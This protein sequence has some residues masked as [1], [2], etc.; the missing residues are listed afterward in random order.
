MIPEIYSDLS[1]EK[2][3]I[4]NDLIH[5]LN[6]SKYAGNVKLIGKLSHVPFKWESSF[7]PQ[8]IYKVLMKQ[9]NIKNQKERIEKKVKYLEKRIEKLKED[10][11][12]INIDELLTMDVSGSGFITMSSHK[13]EQLQIRMLKMD[14]MLKEKDESIT[15]LNRKIQVDEIRMIMARNEEIK[16]LKESLVNT[17][18]L[19]IDETDGERSK[20]I[21]SDIEFMSVEFLKIE[22]LI[23]SESKKCGIEVL[24]VS[25]VIKKYY[26]NENKMRILIKKLSGFI[27]GSSVE[28]SFHDMIKEKGRTAAIEKMFVTY[29]SMVEH[30]LMNENR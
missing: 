10:E 27:K 15:E 23:N 11:G 26:L 14:E 19:Q 17:S 22:E 16:L 29:Q 3:T 25:D 13:I 18:K 20:P 28:K 21:N 1:L 6:E 9:H 7:V 12:T 5:H 2:Q 4:V 8:K 24:D 30:V